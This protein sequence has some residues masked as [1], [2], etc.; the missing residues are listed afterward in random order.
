M[1]FF[2]TY[3]SLLIL[4]AFIVV[5]YSQRCDKVLGYNLSFDKYICGCI[6]S[7]GIDCYSGNTGSTLSLADKQ[8]LTTRDP[9]NNIFVKQKQARKQGN[10]NFGIP[11]IC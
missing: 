10:K 8:A 11:K 9:Y 5:C 1:G 3:D 6:S 4:V 7:I 2:R